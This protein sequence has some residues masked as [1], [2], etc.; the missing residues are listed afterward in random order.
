M[1]LEDANMEYFKDLLKSVEIVLKRFPLKKKS[2]S[3]FIVV[4]NSWCKIGFQKSVTSSKNLTKF[5]INI[6]ISLA[7]INERLGISNDD[8]D[9]LVFQLGDRVNFFLPNK[10]PIWWE[11]LATHESLN[12]VSNEIV[13]IINTTILP[14][15]EKYTKV[16]NV[17]DLCMDANNHR[18]FNGD[19]RKI[20]LLILLLLEDHPSRANEY[21]ERLKIIS[22]NENM[23]EE[24]EDFIKQHFTDKNKI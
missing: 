3:F 21:K 5:T 16:N 15:F 9:K 17:I 4:N 22:K 23:E 12:A 20:S 14:L 1:L 24:Y 8:P 18:W 2:T 10:E 19:F 11:L 7:K 6:G 13:S